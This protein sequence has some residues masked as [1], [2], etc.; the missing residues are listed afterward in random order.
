M[1]QKKPVIKC[2]ILQANSLRGLALIMVTEKDPTYINGKVDKFFRSLPV[3][4][5]KSIDKTDIYSKV[6]LIRL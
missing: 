5:I 2:T 4:T 1:L 6:A 3:S